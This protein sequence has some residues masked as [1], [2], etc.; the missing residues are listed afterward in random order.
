MFFLSWGACLPICVIFRPVAVV[1]MSPVTHNPSMI[2]IE[3][4]GSDK[5]AAFHAWPVWLTGRLHPPIMAVLIIPHISGTVI[6]IIQGEW[7]M[8][9]LK[10][11]HT[12]VGCCHRECSTRHSLHTEKMDS[13]SS[14]EPNYC[15]LKIKKDITSFYSLI[16][17]PPISPFIHA[18]FCP[19]PYFH[20][21]P[22]TPLILQCNQKHCPALKWRVCQIITQQCSE[23][24]SNTMCF[25][26]WVRNIEAG[27]FR[28]RERWDFMLEGSC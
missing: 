27:R 25:W 28:D 24:C 7:L 2:S 8:S 10:S 1:K 11:G 14:Y 6:G 17:H 18:H 19:P 20:P 3:T 22:P 21:P 9:S 23:C 12:A 26:M 4:V 16:L 5:H 13:Y 15:I